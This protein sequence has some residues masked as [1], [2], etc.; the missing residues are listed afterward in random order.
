[1]FFERYGSGARNYLGLHGWGSDRNV[2]KPLSPYVPTDT[3]FFSA[4]LP[5]V[6]DSPRPGEW[7][8][9]YI[10]AAVI[11]AI[12]SLDVKAVTI[13]GHCGGAV[14][15]LLAAHTGPALI[16]RVVAIDPFA[17]LP[18]YFRLFTGEGFGQRAYSATFAS[19]VGRWVTNQALNAGRKDRTDMTGSFAATDHEVARRYLQLFSELSVDDVRGLSTPVDLIYGAQTFGAVKKSIALLSEALPRSR[20]VRLDGSRHMPITE[21]TEQLAGIIFRSHLIA[22]A[23]DDDG[24]QVRV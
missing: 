21:A 8:V 11:E 24:K 15:G 3:S 5:G 22:S 9:E 18:R 16:E 17:Y 20:K 4:D 19:P 2:F 14:F 23:D 6:G 10:V 13:V 7:K 12:R 1:V